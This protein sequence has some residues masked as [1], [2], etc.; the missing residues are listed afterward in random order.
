MRWILAAVLVALTAL[1]GHTTECAQNSELL[2]EYAS[3]K[4]MEGGIPKGELEETLPAG[5]IVTLIVDRETREWKIL[6]VRPDAITCVVFE[7]MEWL[8]DEGH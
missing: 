4:H 6:T 1:P 8:S 2:A 7:G 3:F 5:S